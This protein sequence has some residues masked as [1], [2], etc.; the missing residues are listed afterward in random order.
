LTKVDKKYLFPSNITEVKCSLLVDC[1]KKE[2]LSNKFVNDL[3]GFE[4]LSAWISR[5][6]EFN[7]NDVLF[8][9]EHTGL[10]SIASTR[11]LNEKQ[12]DI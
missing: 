8:C 2:F 10:Y 5:Q 6:I 12:I 3:S 9:G 1:E 11:F 4:D 7:S